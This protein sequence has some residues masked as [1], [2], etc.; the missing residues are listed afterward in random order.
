MDST[1]WID[2]TSRFCGA[3]VQVHQTHNGSSYFQLPEQRAYELGPRTDS[4]DLI[5]ALRPG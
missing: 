2:R 5:F 1:T 3:Q 4:S